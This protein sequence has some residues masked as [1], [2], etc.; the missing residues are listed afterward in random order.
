M[1]SSP[2][3]VD[4]LHR[5][6]PAG[7]AGDGGRLEEKCIGLGWVRKGRIVHIICS[8]KGYVCHTRQGN[9]CLFSSCCLPP[10]LTSILAKLGS[11]WLVSKFVS[12]LVYFE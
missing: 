5:E 12:K 6:P 7:A 10:D 8:N 4:R 11:S 3:S 9:R 2:P 1:T